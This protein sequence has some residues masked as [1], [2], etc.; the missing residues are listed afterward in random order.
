MKMDLPDEL[1]GE[2]LMNISTNDILNKY[3]STQ[4]KRV[5]DNLWCRLFYRDF[6]IKLNDTQYKDIY[7][8]GKR[9][10]ITNDKIEEAKDKYRVHDETV[11]KILN[12][13]SFYQIKNGFIF[14]ADI[15][16]LK[17]T[18]RKNKLVKISDIN[19]CSYE[20]FIVGNTRYIVDSDY[21]RD[22]VTDILPNDFKF[23]LYGFGEMGEI[24]NLFIP[25]SLHQQACV[26]NH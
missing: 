6:N 21:I 13:L 22:F 18:K 4:W 10:Y 15:K 3:V 23:E 26:F 5:I 14:K 16:Q 12:D 7:Y 11:S 9:L 8:I 24:Y 2:I 25:T 1:I 17:I 20:S 19:I